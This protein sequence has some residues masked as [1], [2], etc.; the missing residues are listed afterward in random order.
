M[1][2]RWDAEQHSWH[3]A[4]FLLGR[5]GDPEFLAQPH[6]LFA[7]A[8]IHLLRAIRSDVAGRPQEALPE[9]RAWQAVPA[10]Q[11]SENPEP[12]I[13]RFVAWRIAALQQRTP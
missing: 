13:D 2:R 6:G 10:W 3:D 9:Y 4:A 1:T 8:D 5:I 11:R 12:T 7:S